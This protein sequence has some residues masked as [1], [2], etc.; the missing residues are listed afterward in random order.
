MTQF[1][2]IRTF[3]LMFAGTL[4]PAGWLSA[5]TTGTIQLLPSAPAQSTITSESATHVQTKT[6]PVQSED[7]KLRLQTLTVD[8]EGRILGLVAPPRSYGAPVKEVHSEIHVLTG[9]GKKI[10]T[11]KV[12]F[13]AHSINVAPDGKV[14][15]AG[16]G[17]VARFNKEGKQLACIELPHIANLLKNNTELRKQAEATIKMQKENFEKA[18]NNIKQQKAKLEAKKEADRTE[19]E[20]RLL[21]QYEQILKSYEVTAKYYET[22]TADKIMASLTSRLRIINGIAMSDKDVF[23]ACGESKGYGYAIW[24]MDHEFKNPQQVLSGLGGCCGQMDIQVSGEDLFVAENT[25]HQFAAYDRNGKP[26][27]RWGK[28]GTNSEGDCFGGCCNP[29]NLRCG[30]KG[31]ILTA[32]SEGIIKRYDTTGKFLGLVGVAKLQGGCKNVAVGASP[33]ASKIYFCDQPGSRVIV[34]EKKK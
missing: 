33:D 3:L 1:A 8:R 21:K 24:R 22:Q 4:L 32:E 11:W 13:H 5:Q 20:N 6:I 18:Q 30:L 29:M 2:W 26:R 19:Q 9:E 16:D 12:D 31:E 25:K 14:F 10:A 28:R 34:L 17:K 23:V 7:G 27:G 15:V